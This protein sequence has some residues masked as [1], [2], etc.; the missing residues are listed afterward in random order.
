MFVLLFF[1]K[2]PQ[3]IPLSAFASVR[4][5]DSEAQTTEEMTGREQCEKMFGTKMSSLVSTLREMTDRLANLEGRNGTAGSASRSDMHVEAYEPRAVDE[6]S[7]G[8]VAV[9]VPRYAE[10]APL[11]MASLQDLKDHR[12]APCCSEGLPKRKSLATTE[13]CSHSGYIPMSSRICCSIGVAFV[14]AC[15]ARIHVFPGRPA[16]DR[17]QRGLGFRDKICDASCQIFAMRNNSEDADRVADSTILMQ[18]L[19]V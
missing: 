11:S 8:D 15:K 7:R 2:A 9:E 14:V 16:A 18:R 12:Q 3:C 5:V 4:Y 10:V 6:A 1:P 19:W 13:I 17:L